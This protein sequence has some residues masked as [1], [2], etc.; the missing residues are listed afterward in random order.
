MSC[1]LGIFLL[2]VASLGRTFT[3]EAR[4]AMLTLAGGLALREWCFDSRHVPSVSMCPS[5]EV[6]DVLLLEK[7]SFLASPPSRGEVVCFRAP[8]ALE[9]FTPRGACYIKRVVATA[10][11]EVSVRGGKLLVNGEPVDEPFLAEPMRYALRSTRVPEGCVFVLGDNRNHS[12]DSHV[13]GALEDKL[14]IGRPL[15]IFWPLQRARG[16]GAF[17]KA[18]LPRRQ[19]RWA[20]LPSSLLRRARAGLPCGAQ[21]Q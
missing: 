1:S 12:Y 17:N 19:L 9:R 20:S 6:G 21:A 3:P 5:F 2:P 10:G 11:D 18:P 13:W 4:E 7:L 16:R 8:P 14:L 15:C